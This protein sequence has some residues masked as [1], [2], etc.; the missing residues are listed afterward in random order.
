MTKEEFQ[1]TR[2]IRHAAQK[3]MA[4]RTGAPLVVAAWIRSIDAYEA[5]Y[6]QTAW[7]IN[8][9]DEELPFWLM[10]LEHDLQVWAWGPEWASEEE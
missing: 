8:V 2:V 5:Q 6:G 4:R 1:R 10:E 9:T 7:P 3:V